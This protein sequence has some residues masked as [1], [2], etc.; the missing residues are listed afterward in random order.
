MSV[1]SIWGAKPQPVPAIKLED[2]K[3][4]PEGFYLQCLYGPHKADLLHRGTAYCRNCYDDRNRQGIL[5]N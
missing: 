3:P 2:F 4:K 5:V 1:K